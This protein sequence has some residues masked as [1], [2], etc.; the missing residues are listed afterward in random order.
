MDPKDFDKIL[1]ELFDKI[2]KKYSTNVM[3]STSLNHKDC[4]NCTQML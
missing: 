3:I 1:D 4:D 2:Y